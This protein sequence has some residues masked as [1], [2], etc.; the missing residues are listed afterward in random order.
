[1][2]I[3][4]KGFLRRLKEAA[5]IARLFGVVPKVAEKIERGIDIVE[6]PVPP[7][8]AETHTDQKKP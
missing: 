8:P 3:T 7:A 5:Q 1:M 6:P 4:L 2:K